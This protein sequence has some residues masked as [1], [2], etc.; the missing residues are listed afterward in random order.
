VCVC[1][2]ACVGGGGGVGGDGN[3]YSPY[4]AT[5][6]MVL[7]ASLP[8]F[9]QNVRIVTNEFCGNSTQHDTQ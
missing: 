6:E 3:L 1:V 4:S 8:T 2:C 7:P 9:L 5:Q